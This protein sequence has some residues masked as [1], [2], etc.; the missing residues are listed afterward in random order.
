MDF[1]SF[2]FRDMGEQTKARIAV[3]LGNFF[4]GTSV[5]AV[6]QIS[7]VLV[8][9]I[10]LTGIRVG[11]VC[12]LFWIMFLIKPINTGF[13]KKDYWRL[14]ICGVLGITCNQTFSMIGMSMTSPIHASL[15]V[16]TTPITISLFAAW[17]LKERWNTFKILGLCLGIT[18]GAVLVFSRDLSAHAS[19][20][21]STG[22]LFVILGAV[23]YSSYIILVKPLMAK[24]SAVHILQWI[25]LF[26]AFFSIPIGWNDI[27]GIQWH[28]FSLT[29][30]LCMSYVVIG[31][32]FLAYQLM[33]FG[34]KKLGASVTG[35]YIYTQPFFATFASV[36]IF[37]EQIN[38]SKML[39]ALMII[40]G[41][42]LTNFKNANDERIK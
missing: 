37:E 41:V 23:C 15:L 1:P 36:L 10:A 33:N 2:Q 35:S 38:L 32:T 6:K 13:Q 30:W 21:Q 26:G 16:L 29:N 19:A 12:L 27:Q 24:Y 4:F 8:P 39:A 14:F 31:A 5:I 25:F 28:L 17:F 40:T 11:V 34:I 42:F 3:L 9:A 22:D 7:P 18:G 20:E